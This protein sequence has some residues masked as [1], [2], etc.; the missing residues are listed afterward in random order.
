ME[1]TEFAPK[2]WEQRFVEAVL[3]RSSSDKGLAARLRRGDNPATEYQSWEL[4]GSLGVDLEKDYQRLPFVTIAAAITK[5]KAAENGSLSLGKALAACYEDGA[6]SK[7][8]KARLRRLLACSEIAEV[9]RI[10]RPILTLI[11]SKVGQPLN[12]Q[13]LLKQLRTFHFDDQRVK[14]QWAQ[15]FYGQPLVEAPVESVTT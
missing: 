7:Q 5:S 2:S 12:Y 11:D 15:E 8:A 3:Q 6:E 13:R 9:C 1:A 14:A 4:L 10:L